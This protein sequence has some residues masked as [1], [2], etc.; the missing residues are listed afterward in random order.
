[1]RTITTHRMEAITGDTPQEAAALFNEAMERLAPMNPTYEREGCTFWVH[2][3]VTYQ[4]AETLTE[5]HDLA[6]DSAHCVE[7]PFI[8]RDL[9]RFGNIDA[10]KK[11]G[12]CT[13]T[14]DRVFISDKACDLLYEA[15]GERREQSEK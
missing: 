7:C 14:G 9:N 11:W 15:R 2:Y 3:K 6:G 10:R 1:M 5:M 13:K 12:T 4:E 8:H